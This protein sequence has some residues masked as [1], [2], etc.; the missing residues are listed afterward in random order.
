M[1]KLTTER[2]ITTHQHPLDELAKSIKLYSDESDPKAGNGRHH[3][4]ARIFDRD[5]NAVRCAAHVDFQHG[6]RGE[7]G[8]T[9]GITAGALL[10]ILIDHFQS[11]QEGPFKCRENAV[12][13]TKLEEA[14]MWNEKRMVD[15]HKRGVLGKNEE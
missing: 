1:T 8:S 11:F 5:K 7:E 15:R 2:E 12:V 13:I 4:E 9:P 14:A 6:P 3:Y 10:S